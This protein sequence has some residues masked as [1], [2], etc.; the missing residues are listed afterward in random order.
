MTATVIE[1]EQI[2]EK[3]ANIVQETLRK[4]MLVSLGAFGLIQDNAIGML[5]KLV[6][7]GEQVSQKRRAQL[8]EMV[9]GRKKDA[10]KASKTAEKRLEKRLENVLH[11]LNIPTRE[12]IR[13]LNTKVTTLSRKVDELKKATAQ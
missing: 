3:E 12:D 11:S 13:S 4:G 1:V 2:E 5:D 10:Q 6:E 7:R 9:E 8:E